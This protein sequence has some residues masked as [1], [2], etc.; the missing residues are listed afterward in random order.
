M[1]NFEFKINGKQATAEDL[2]KL[3]RLAS[4]PE[5]QEDL[6]VGLAALK[7]VKEVKGEKMSG[8]LIAQEEMT[9]KV[10]GEEGMKKAMSREDMKEVNDGWDMIEAMRRKK[11]EYGER[12]EKEQTKSCVSCG[13]EIPIGANFCSTCGTKF[14]KL[15]NIEDDETE[16]TKICQN[17]GTEGKMSEKF[18]GMCGNKFEVPK[19]KQLPRQDIIKAK[20]ISSDNTMSVEEFMKVGNAEEALKILEKRQGKMADD[21]EAGA[22]A[23]KQEQQQEISH[24][25]GEKS[26]LETENVHDEKELVFSNIEKI[27]DSQKK[28]QEKKNEAGG[29]NGKNSERE[30]T[31]AEYVDLEQ[32]L[33][34]VPDKIENLV[35]FLGTIDGIQGSNK[36]YPSERLKKDVQNVHDELLKIDIHD[37]GIIIDTLRKITRTGGLRDKVYGIFLVEKMHKL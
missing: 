8:F 22:A 29:D 33:K 31:I 5:D 12:G 26:G 11:K 7:R 28:S 1:P 2:K 17:C 37:K 18:C 20:D 9:K 15:K 24:A 10:L 4:N 34:K 36:F 30:P 23:E 16:K 25:T 35:E 32:K 13:T 6:A 19:K 21:E 14:E 3:S 27:D